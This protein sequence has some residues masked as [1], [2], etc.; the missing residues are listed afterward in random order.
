ML[1]VI[2]AIAKQNTV[3]LDV[4]TVQGQLKA[5]N[6]QVQPKNL[7]SVRPKSKNIFNSLNDTQSNKK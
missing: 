6:R 3:T 1:L 7:I 2:V 5:T 4:K